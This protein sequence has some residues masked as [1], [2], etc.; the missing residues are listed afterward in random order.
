MQECSVEFRVGGNDLQEECKKVK[1]CLVHTLMMDHDSACPAGNSFAYFCEE[2]LHTF[3]G[4]CLFSGVQ[5]DIHLNIRKIFRCRRFCVLASGDRIE[6]KHLQALQGVS[7]AAV[8]G[9]G[10]IK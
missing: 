2:I 6:A 5:I 3:S 7:G 1:C 8:P 4:I 9:R 10:K